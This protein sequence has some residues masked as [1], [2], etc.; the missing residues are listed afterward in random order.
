MKRLTILV[1]GFVEEEV[2]KPFLKLYWEE[3]FG[4]VDVIRF[5][6]APDLKTRFVS[7]S[8]KRLREGD[9]VLCLV[10][11]F[12]EPFRVCKPNMTPEEQFDRVQAWI[13]EEVVRNIAPQLYER[14][15]AFP[16]VME[17]ETWLLADADLWKEDERTSEPET[18]RHPVARLQRIFKAKNKRYDKKTDGISLFKKA[19]VV[20]VF[21]DNCPHFKKLIEWIKNPVPLITTPEQLALDQSIQEEYQ[22]KMALENDLRRQLERFQ[23]DDATDLLNQYTFAKRDLE[24]FQRQHSKVLKR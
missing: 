13:H 16:V 14:F 18:I 7:I 11:V 21:E 22:K 24:A 3:T 20:R 23:G 19:S 9:F 10:D 17:I 5:D 15:A 8:S 1:E 6:G 12:E 2:V 4:D